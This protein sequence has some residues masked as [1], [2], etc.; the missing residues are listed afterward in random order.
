MINSFILKY[1]AFLVLSLD[2][3]IE[4]WRSQANNTPHLR[5]FYGHIK[6]C[7][8]VAPNGNLMLELSIDLYSLIFMCKLYTQQIIRAL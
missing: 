4:S 8:I 7:K 6:V 1:E 2:K 3:F 5:N